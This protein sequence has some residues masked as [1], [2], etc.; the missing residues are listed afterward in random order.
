MSWFAV[1][2]LASLSAGGYDINLPFTSALCQPLIATGPPLTRSGFVSLLAMSTFKLFIYVNRDL[3]LPQ[4]LSVLID[5]SIAR[6]LAA[7]GAHFRCTAY[8]HGPPELE[9]DTVSNQA[10]VAKHQCA[11]KDQW[12]VTALGLIVEAASKLTHR[13]DNVGC[14]GHGRES[15]SLI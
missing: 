1:V 9:T 4:S 10:P 12:L 5:N 3:L 14:L 2:S 8:Q 13:R 15:H 11:I 6:T 7:F